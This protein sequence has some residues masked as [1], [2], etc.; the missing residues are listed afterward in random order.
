MTAGVTVA[1]I[2]LIVF[3]IGVLTGVIAIIAL[4]AKRKNEQNRRGS[5]ESPE[6][7]WPGR[8]YG[9]SGIPG[10]WGGGTRAE[11]RPHWPDEPD[12]ERTA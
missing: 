12:N 11:D 5:A 1:V 7:R 4:S 8:D 3:I 9:A 2:W 6:D 10:H